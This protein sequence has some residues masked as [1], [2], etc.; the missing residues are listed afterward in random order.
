MHHRTLL[1]VRAKIIPKFLSFVSVLL[2]FFP[3]DSSKR[4]DD[5]TLFSYAFFACFFC[6]LP[7]VLWEYVRKIRP[8]AAP[9]VDRLF[10]FFFN[11]LFLF[12]LLDG[13]EKRRGRGKVNEWTIARFGT[14]RV[15]LL[16][17]HCIPVLGFSYFHHFS[18]VAIGVVSFFFSSFSSGFTRNSDDNGRDRF[19][20]FF[21]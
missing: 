14:L 21:I 7:S 13:K 19:T 16:V 8:S 2:F 12:A 20:R 10:E 6:I 9:F 15:I 11:D 18:P 4:R 5:E 1:V 17:L 3:P